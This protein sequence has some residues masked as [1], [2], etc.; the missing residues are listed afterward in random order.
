MSDTPRTDR[1]EG[2]AMEWQGS[3]HVV[4]ASFARGLE[5]ELAN[6]NNRIEHLER[7]S[8]KTSVHLVSAGIPA[9]GYNHEAVDLLATRL[10]AAER[11]LAELRAQ[12]EAMHEDLHEYDEKREWTE[13]ENAELRE[14]LTRLVLDVQEYEAW[15]RPCFALE[16][17]KNALNRSEC[18]AQGGC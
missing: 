13:R 18:H 17:A 6:A 9:F 1:E 14:A 5:R 7:A 11:E 15:Q 16:E 2:Q 10:R 8:A 12:N 4:P 3:E